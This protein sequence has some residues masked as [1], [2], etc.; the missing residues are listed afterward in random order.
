MKI[1]AVVLAAGSSSRLGQPKQLF[2]YQGQTLVRRTAGAALGAGCT[3]VAIVV[4]SERKKIAGNLHDLEV[5]ILPNDS[6]RRGIGTS[7]RTG[8]AALK[9]CDA[10]IILACDQPH[11]G[12]TLIRQLVARHEET[13]KPMVASAYAG[14]LGVPALFGR[15]SFEQLS[16]LGD[17][18]GAKILFSA[19]PNEVAQV[20]FPGGA[21]DLDTPGDWARLSSAR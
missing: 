12:A 9:D 3:P 18:E 17:D 13:Q 15:S 10:L 19:R 8:V 1:G 11:V 5:I 7:I 16:L 4:G 2:L 21:V 14:T 6:W 20:D